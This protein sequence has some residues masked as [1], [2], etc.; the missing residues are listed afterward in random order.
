[1]DGFIIPLEHIRFLAKRIYGN[2]GEIIDCAVAYLEADG[3]GPLQR[4]THEHNHLFIVVNEQTRILLNGMEK[5]LNPDEEFLVEGEVPRSVWN[6]M[7]GTAVT[8]G[9]SVK[10]KRA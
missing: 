4:H 9:R 7:G 6:H 1:M 8:A 3:G 5:I 2:C 10:A